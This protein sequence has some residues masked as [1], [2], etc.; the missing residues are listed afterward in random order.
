[1]ILVFPG[2]IF[3]F[4]LAFFYEWVDRKFYARLQNRYGPLHTGPSG[5]LQPF[6]DFV[7]L[8]AKEDITPQAADRLL[9]TATPIFLLAIPTAAL[10]CIPM[11]EL[12]ALVSFEGDLIYVIF[13]STLISIA[14][15]LAAWSSTNPFSIVGG[16]RA[17]FQMLGY[18]VPMAIVMVCPAIAAGTLNISG[19]VARQA[20]TGIWFILS[21]PLGF[22]ILLICL[23]AEVK[24]IPFDIPEA[25]TEIV[26]G[27]LTEFS[28]RKL[29]LMRLSIDMEL[30]FAAALTTALF[31]GGPAGPAPIPP[32]IY[33][34]I[35]TTIVVL[36]LSN[37][38]TLFA[39]F[40]IDQMVHGSWKFLTPLA[41]LQVILVELTVG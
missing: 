29:A 41:I 40:R 13:L 15:F 33:F 34:L 37:L 28:G 31:L 4:G 38:R 23:L 25:E 9:F 6:A 5:L 7:K 20:A 17:A 8:L 16:L 3:L 12:T 26:A 19:I 36:I 35:K 21:Q 2:I 10:F 22:A 1:Q 14:T 24:R 18:E 27:W 32:I 30:V 11:T 39:R